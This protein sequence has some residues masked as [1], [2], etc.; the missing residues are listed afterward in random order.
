MK[1]EMLTI[2]NWYPECFNCR[3]DL[4]IGLSILL[5]LFSLVYPAKVGEKK[6]LGLNFF[7]LKILGTEFKVSFI[8][9]YLVV[10][11]FI[12]VLGSINFLINYFDKSPSNSFLE[13]QSKYK[14]VFCIGGK[15]ESFQEIKNEYGYFQKVRFIG[16]SKTILVPEFTFEDNNKFCYDNSKLALQILS[17]MD[18]NSS[19][20]NLKFCGLDYDPVENILFCLTEIYVR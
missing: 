12:V 18:R 13:I 17:R 3:Y 16:E 11:G 8:K 9:G 4:L 20:E 7:K 15:F 19:E 1:E 5:I 2:Y 14:N 10:F 6:Q